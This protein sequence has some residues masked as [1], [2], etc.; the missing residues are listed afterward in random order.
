VPMPDDRMLELFADLGE[1]LRGI[2]AAEVAA[3]DATARAVG[4]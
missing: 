1:R 2:H 4:R 3:L